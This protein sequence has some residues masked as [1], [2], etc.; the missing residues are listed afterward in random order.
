MRVGIFSDIHSNLEALDAVLQFLHSQGADCF[1][2]CGDIVG[3]GP[4]PRACIEKIRALRGPVVAGN[5]DWG[6]LGQT[7]VHQF[8]LAARA[9]IEWTKGQLDE[10]DVSYLESLSLTER[11]EPLY[12]VHASPSAPEQW[13]YIFVVSEAEA[14]MDYFSTRVCIVGHSHY[15][16][17][18]ERRNDGRAKL[19]R[20]QRFEIRSGA[21]YVVNVGSVGQPRDGDP[22]ACCVLFDDDTKLMSFHRVEY[23]VK[24]VQEKILRAGLPE[25]LAT[26]LSSGR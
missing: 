18:V 22:R 10:S 6:V 25:F 13:E 24:A 26:R 14:E 5:H 8:N 2:C 12:L 16:F 1:A 19:V 15:P 11:F 17:V 4:D 9:A 20:R 23:D 21:K 3:Y 7:P